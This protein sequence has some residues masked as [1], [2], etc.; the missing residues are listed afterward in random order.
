MESLKILF[1][2]VGSAILYG[3]LHDQ[4][5]ARV[6]VE[7]FTIGHEPIFNTESPTLLAFGWGVIA[8]WYVG[9]FLSVPAILTSRVGSWPKIS[10]WQLARPIGI[11]LIVMGLSSLA[12]GIAGYYAAKSGAAPIHFSLEDLVPPEKHNAF[13]ADYWSHSAAYQVGE[14]GGILLCIG[15]VLWRWYLEQLRR[16]EERIE[17]QA[18]STSA[19]NPYPSP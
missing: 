12:S 3:I 8:T 19:D 11:L 9:L 10:A 2:C 1:L 4:V 18:A 13:V 7:Y 14:V 6:C 16:I 17:T 15:V 5:T